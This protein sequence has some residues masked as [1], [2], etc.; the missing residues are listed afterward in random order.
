MKWLGNWKEMIILLTFRSINLCWCVV[1]T[2]SLKS[3]GVIEIS[4]VFNKFTSL[5]IGSKLVENMNL[6]DNNI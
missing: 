4:Y 3:V 6:L 2:I 1:N 5:V